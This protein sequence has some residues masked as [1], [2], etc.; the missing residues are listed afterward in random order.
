MDR[1]LLGV[2]WDGLLFVDSHL[3]FGLRSAPKIFTAVED[4]IEWCVRQRGI[5]FIEHYLDDYIV[6][7]PPD[8]LTCSSNLTTLLEECKVLGA[9][10]AEEKTEGPVTVLTF[11]GIKIDTMAQ[12]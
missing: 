5:E 9:P 1:C 4:A 8:S 7:G 10:M 11:L 3:P 6:F 2:P 12:C